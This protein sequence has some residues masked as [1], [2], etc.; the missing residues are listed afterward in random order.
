M[1]QNYRTGAYRAPDQYRHQT[2]RQT[3]AVAGAGDYYGMFGTWAGNSASTGVNARSGVY[4]V[5][6]V[7]WNNLENV[8]AHAA[9]LRGLN[10]VQ[11]SKNE[12]WNRSRAANDWAD[13]N[14]NKARKARGEDV[15][16]L[17]VPAHRDVPLGDGWETNPYYSQGLGNKTV[18]SQAELEKLRSSFWMA[19]Q[20]KFDNR[21]NQLKAIDAAG[22]QQAYDD[23]ATSRAEAAV[24]HSESLRASELT[25]PVGGGGRGGGGGGSLGSSRHVSAARRAEG[26][27]GAAPSRGGTVARKR[28]RASTLTGTPLGGGSQSAAQLLG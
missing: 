28:L 14:D 26:P 24:P 5:G 8:Q 17:R 15:G 4:L 1:E 12:Y 10:K 21:V 3:G 18:G 25:R 27:R 23:L 19:Q 22:G 13:W 6:K 20:D 11:A 9:G 2:Q 16:A 7:D